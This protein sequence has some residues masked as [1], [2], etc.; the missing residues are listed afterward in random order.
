MVCASP[1]PQSLLSPL[2]HAALSEAHAAPSPFTQ[3]SVP[4]HP[5]SC[6]LPASPTHVHPLE[7]MKDLKGKSNCAIRDTRGLSR[8]L[9]QCCADILV[10]IFVPCELVRQSLDVLKSSLMVALPQK[11]SPEAVLGRA[12]FPNRSNDVKSHHWQ[13][14]NG[15]ARWDR[16]QGD[17]CSSGVTQGVCHNPA[18]WISSAECFW[19]G[20]AGFGRQ[21]TAGRCWE[22][23]EWPIEARASGVTLGACGC[24]RMA[25]SPGTSGLCTTAFGGLTIFRLRKLN[26]DMLR[27]ERRRRFRHRCCLTLDRIVDREDGPAIA[28]SSYRQG[29]SL[30]I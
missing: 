28:W 24:R 15:K 5:A 21:A 29:I 1:C 17:S 7:G 11:G 22:L 20:A 27:L 10:Q 18:K 19:G 30:G 26:L 6:L 12:H 4:A 8:N 9:T 3:T 13:F 25:H 16:A 2:Q 23:Q 14:S